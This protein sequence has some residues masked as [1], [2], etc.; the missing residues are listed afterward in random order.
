MHKVIIAIIV[1]AVVIGFIWLMKNKTE[2]EKPEEAKTNPQATIASPVNNPTQTVL[3]DK[4]VLVSKVAETPGDTAPALVSA[5]NI[6][7]NT[8]PTIDTAT[9]P[10]KLDIVLQASPVG[11]SSFAE[12]RPNN[13]K[14]QLENMLNGRRISE[15]LLRKRELQQYKIQ[16]NTNT[17]GGTQTSAIDPQTIGKSLRDMDALERVPTSGGDILIA[18]TNDSP[19]SLPEDISNQIL[20]LVAN[21]SVI[22]VKN[23]VAN[24]AE[25]RTNV[26]VAPGQSMGAADKTQQSINPVQTKGT[27][28]SNIKSSNTDIVSKII[29]QIEGLIPKLNEKQV[30]ITQ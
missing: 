20:R 23:N 25:L 7:I 14:E 30:V 19:K 5:S 6:P 4:S 10:N 28:T 26:E 24:P 8:Q 1:I 17:P 15:G 16:V 3:A 13:V 11:A 12:P 9:M 22:T 27:E 18:R 29:N 21:S 2:A